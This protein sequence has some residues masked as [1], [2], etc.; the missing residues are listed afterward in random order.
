MVN[1]T[2]VG[3]EGR[4]TPF[5]Y[6]QRRVLLRNLGN[7]RFENV[8]DQAGARLQAVRGGSRRRVRRHRQRRRRGTWSWAT[9]Q[10]GSGCWSTN[11]GNRNH[12]VG[13]R[14]VGPLGRDMLGARVAVIRRDGSTLWRTVRSDGSYDRRTIQRVVVGLGRRRRNR[15]YAYSGR[16]ATSRTGQTW[17]SID[18]QP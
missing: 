8:T 16:M 2:I 3:N 13:L 1:G 9:M 17:L 5:P 11:I 6:G 4:L 7:G 15:E 14:V 10:G 12:W 18:G